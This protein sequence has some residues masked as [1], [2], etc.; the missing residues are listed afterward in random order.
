MS[1]DV[2]KS[3]GVKIVQYRLCPRVAITGAQQRPMEATILLMLRWGC[4]AIH[5]EKANNSFRSVCGGDCRMVQ[6][7]SIADIFADLADQVLL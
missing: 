3:Y 1:R 5:S 4:F 7:C 2:N 6:R